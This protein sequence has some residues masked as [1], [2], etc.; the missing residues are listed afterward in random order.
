MDASKINWILAIG[1][2]LA[3]V[4]LG[5]LGYHLF[6]SSTTGLQKMRQ[7]LAERDR[8]LAALRTGMDDH[9]NEVSR[10]VADLQRDSEALASRLAQDARSL[11]GKN[12]PVSNM[13]IATGQMSPEGGSEEPAMPRD[14]AKGSGGTLSEDFG[15]KNDEDAKAPQPPRY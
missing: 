14:Y 12:D 7:R 3:G 2:L 13:E 6:N 4:G 15:L 11:G 10:L 5:A 1:C 9:L 8:E